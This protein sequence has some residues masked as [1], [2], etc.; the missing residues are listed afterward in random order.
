MSKQGEPMDIAEPLNRCRLMLMV[1]AI[2][3]AS[4]ILSSAVKAGDVASVIFYDKS[5]SPTQFMAA[6]KKLVPMV[7]G[8]GVAAVIAADSQLAGRVEADGLFVEG[9][10][11]NLENAIARFSPQKIV[12]CGGI[13]TKHKALSVGD[14]RPDFVF[15]G[16]LDGDIKPDP[17]AK[18]LALADWWSKL[19][20]T[21]CVVMGG[22]VVESVIDCSAS[23]AE[24]VALGKA[25]FS[26]A[27]GAAEAVHRA[28]ELLDRHAPI[29]EEAE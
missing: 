10:L 24:F 4:D 13:K 23:G 29:F 8:E 19:I 22:A 14:M 3:V 26:D 18:N 25:V 9:A 20:E 11:E 21:P 28:N 7:Q 12:G 2:E 16:K 15:F 5:N 6:C 1:P 17:H 27:E